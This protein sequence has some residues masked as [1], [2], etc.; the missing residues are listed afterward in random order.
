MK[1]A[2]SNL[3]ARVLAFFGASVSE[4]RLKQ[5]FGVVLAGAL[6]V[7][8]VACSSSPQASVG[9]QPQGGRISANDYEAGQ[10]GKAS[11]A[12]AKALVD[13]AKQNVNKVQGFDE[14][15]EEVRS[16]VP[17]P[18]EDAGDVITDA[19]DR[20][21]RDAKVGFRNLQKNLNRAGDNLEDATQAAQQ[22]AKQTGRNI[23][24]NAKET[25]RNIQRN[26]ENAAD[27]AKDKV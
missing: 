6:L 5:I 24:Q 19:A 7:T 3:V 22:N 23:Q 27:F 25:G 21:N 4:L 14:L 18:A 12:K 8:T 16:G 2:I 1:T 10:A 17:N 26:A 20:A 11:Q 15:V 13:R 9:Y